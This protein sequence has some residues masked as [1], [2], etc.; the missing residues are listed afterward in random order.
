MQQLRRNN[1]S[2][3]HAQKQVWTFAK[4]SSRNIMCEDLHKLL[5]SEEQPQ[6]TALWERSHG[7]R[8]RSGRPEL[9][10]Q[11]PRTKRHWNSLVLAEESK[12]KRENCK[13][14]WA[15]QSPVAAKLHT[16]QAWCWSMPAEEW[17]KNRTCH[18]SKVR[19]DPQWCRKCSWSLAGCWCVKTRNC[20]QDQKHTHASRK[21]HV[22]RGGKKNQQQQQQRHNWTCFKFLKY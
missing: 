7:W 21:I 22:R 14:W 5:S 9:Q 20:C 16:R 18:Y 19:K 12:R 6:L 17:W 8:S 15:Q 11:A 3:S 1:G 2:Y 4:I 10:L 13:S